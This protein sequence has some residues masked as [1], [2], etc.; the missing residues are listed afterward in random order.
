MRTI[1]RANI[2]KVRSLTQREIN[3]RKDFRGIVQSYNGIQSTVR[4]LLPVE[5]WDLWE[6]SDNEINNIIS[7][8][9]H[10]Q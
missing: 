6:G 3:K 8:T 2:I 4:D 5:L 10:N 1:G 9:I 7:D